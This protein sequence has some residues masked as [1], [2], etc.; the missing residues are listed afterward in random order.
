MSTSFYRSR[1][2][3]LFFG[4]FCL[5]TTIVLL[6]GC[7]K[8]NPTAPS[9]PGLLQG[10]EAFH[11]ASVASY[12]S[13]GA[14]VSYV[15][16]SL[17]L[18]SPSGS[19]IHNNALIK[20]LIHGIYS[21]LG[22]NTNEL[23]D[24]LVY[25]P[26]LNLYLNLSYVSNIINASFYSDASGTQPTGYVKITLP[27]DVTD[28]T[29]PTS[30][31]SYPANVSVDINITGGNIPC[32]GNIQI[33]FTGNSGANTMTGTNTITRDNVVFTLNLGLDNNLNTSGSITI[34]ERG[35]TVSATNVTGYVLDTLDC[36]VSISPYNWIGTG[37]INLLTGSLY[38]NVNTGSGISTALSDS[39]GNLNLNYGDGSK[40]TI[41]DALSGD[42]T[43]GGT[44][45]GTPDSIYVISGTPQSTK[46]NTDFPSPLIAKVIDNSGNPV[47]GIAVN[48]SSVVGAQ[49]C[50]FPNG[51]HSENVTSDFMG[52]VSIN[53]KANSSDGTYSVTA[54]VS[55]I[56][57]KAIFLL[58]NT[59]LT[60]TYNDPIFYNYWERI[61]TDLNND[62]Q[63]VGYDMSYL[64]GGGNPTGNPIPVFWS[65]PTSSEQILPKSANDTLNSVNGLNDNSQIVGNGYYY[66]QNSS[67]YVSTNALYWSSPTAVPRELQVYT[68]TV[69]AVANDINNNGQIVGYCLND[70]SSYTPLYW[71]SPTAAPIE[72][73]GVGGGGVATHITSDGQIVGYVY[74]GA[75][76]VPAVWSSPSSQP[77][78]PAVL[79]GDDYSQVMSIN[80]HGVSVGISTANAPA[81]AYTIPHAVIWET[82]NSPAQQLP[83]SAS[84]GSDWTNFAESINNYGVIVGAESGYG[85]FYNR[86][87]IWKN[88]QATDLNLLTTF[89]SSSNWVGTATLINDNSWIIGSEGPN[90]LVIIFSGRLLDESFPSAQY[91]LIPK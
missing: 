64:Q 53:A 48:F 70:G 61:I 75:A 35:A 30:Y 33:V 57:S 5:I 24:S 85:D 88:G 83:L 62:G 90:S 19:P 79:N 6:N 37:K 78:V 1:R 7:Q 20:N 76:L 51:T 14:G 40:E 10:N 46:V 55:G 69:Q 4:L 47:S 32:Q 3:I 68:N 81:P 31:S 74:N 56:A 84:A 89:Q 45:S 58:T 72:L 82:P 41:V 50:T 60:A 13:V 23:T 67:G 65:T 9:D 86:G 66:N 29:D 2:K 54:A 26:F 16:K 63:T 44:Q 8:N 34:N 43:G 28:P 18:C 25:I 38:L 73:Q 77:V 87:V 42:L 22:K 11:A 91:I 15:F 52:E 21:P 17:Q 12:Q 49:G 59:S 39:L 27:S 71:S 80:S 36:D